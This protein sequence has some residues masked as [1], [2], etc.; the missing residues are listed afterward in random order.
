[1]SNRELLP[2]LDKK[3]GFSTFCRNYENYKITIADKIQ[4]YESDVEAA[5]KE[6]LRLQ[7]DMQGHQKALQQ[8][9]DARSNCEEKIQSLQ[10]QARRARGGQEGLQELDIQ[11]NSDISD[12]QRRYACEK[13]EVRENAK[14]LESARSQNAA[15]LK[16]LQKN[17]ELFDRMKAY[18]EPT[19]HRVNA[20]INSFP[21]QAEKIRAAVGGSLAKLTDADFTFEE[22]FNSY[23]ESNGVFR[24]LKFMETIDCIINPT[25]YAYAFLQ[26]KDF[27]K[28]RILMIF[29]F[30]VG[31][32]LAFLKSSI[33]IPISVILS[34]FPVSSLRKK[35]SQYLSDSLDREELELYHTILAFTEKDIERL[36]RISEGLPEG[37]A[38]AYRQQVDQKISKMQKEMQDAKNQVDRCTSQLLPARLK[39]KALREEYDEITADTHRDNS[40]LYTALQKQKNGMELTENMVYLIQEYEKK[41][42]DWTN[43]NDKN[44]SNIKSLTEAIQSSQNKSRS[45]ENEIRD[46]R[47]ASAKIIARLEQIEQVTGNS[48][49]SISDEEKLA[50]LERKEEAEIL[51]VRE[52]YARDREDLAKALDAEAERRVRAIEKQIDDVNKQL[53]QI[54]KDQDRLEAEQRSRNFAIEQAQAKEAAAQKHFNEENHLF[55]RLKTSEVWLKNLNEWK[56]KNRS[57]LQMDVTSFTVADTNFIIGPEG[58][59]Q[60]MHGCRPCVLRYQTDPE[61]ADDAPLNLL[62]S[63]IKY[64]QASIVLSNLPNMVQFALLNEYSADDS[65][66]GQMRCYTKSKIDELYRDLRRKHEELLIETNYGTSVKDFNTNYSAERLQADHRLTS[67]EFFYLRKNCDLTGDMEKKKQLQEMETN[68]VKLLKPTLFLFILP[69]PNSDS[70]PMNHDGL[71]EIVRGNCQDYGFVPIFLIPEEKWTDAAEG[72]GYQTEF[73]KAVTD[74]ERYAKASILQDLPLH[75]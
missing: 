44:E 25:L 7:T 65:M 53:E 6:I 3:Q 69:T 62:K 49:G 74:L 5:R 64:I 39:Q 31:I 38:K 17:R 35:H 51:R 2:G 60:L 75:S 43:R 12:I 29:L 18:R 9:L 4:E 59:Y 41:L 71:W 42:A 11:M 15:Y 50:Q 30:A 66:A 1:M 68:V 47:V 37:S 63:T 48:S 32:F 46:F 26:K 13:K 56:E 58:P 70:R 27:I 16:K 57:N 28:T 8:A 23:S 54:Q 55:C 36:A 21:T 67:E 20:L 33:F 22:R 10:R 24:P 61:S 73:S 52:K 19:E 14:L 72:R 40:R 34:I 45:L